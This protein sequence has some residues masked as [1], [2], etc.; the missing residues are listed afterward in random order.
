ML[1]FLLDG[2]IL[3]VRE[4]MHSFFGAETKLIEYNIKTWQKRIYPNQ[5]EPMTESAIDFIKKYYLPKVGL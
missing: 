2:D 4:T 1:V 3:K 5:F